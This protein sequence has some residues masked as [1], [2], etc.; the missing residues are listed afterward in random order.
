MRDSIWKCKTVGDSVWQWVTVRDYG[1]TIVSKWISFQDSVLLWVSTYQFMLS[2]SIEV[3]FTEKVGLFFEVDTMILKP[4]KMLW[5]W[6][7]E[8]MRKCCIYLVIEISKQFWFLTI[9][10]ENH[11]IQM[12]TC[13]DEVNI[14][15]WNQR[16]KWRKKVRE[17]WPID[18]N[19]QCERLNLWYK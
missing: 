15:P 11:Q 12:A 13:F 18:S 19:S 6:N 8:H 14:I 7:K 4:E 3:Y 9:P 2:C 1:P 10:R 5:F 16:V 17:P